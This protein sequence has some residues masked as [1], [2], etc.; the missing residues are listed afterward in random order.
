VPD[1]ASLL[2]IVVA[3]TILLPIAFLVAVAYAAG[4]RRR[5]IEIGGR[6]T[7]LLTILGG[8]S[9]GIFLLTG[10]DELLVL[11]PILGAA[12]VLVANLWRRRQRIQAGQVILGT[13][14][15]WAIL[16]TSYLV[17]LVLDPTAYDTGAVVTWFAL[18]AAGV[19]TGL[20]LIA[21]GNPPEPAPSVAAAA[22]E[23][24]SRAYGSIVTAIREPG[25]VGP[26]GTSELAAVVGFVVG[27]LLVP[28]LV[29]ADLPPVLRFAI[30]IVVGAVLATEAYIRAMPVRSRR[31]FEAFS[32][33]GEWELAEARR[34]APGS[35]PTTPAEAAEWL[36]ANPETDANRWIQVDVLQLAGRFD[37]A[38]KAAGR[39]ADTTPEDRFIRAQ[40]LDSIDWRS[41]GEGDL[42][43]LRAAAAEITPADGDPRLR[44]EVSIATAEVRRR[45]A[46]GR[47]TPG[48]ALDPLLEVR[49]KLGRRAD[50]QVGR[51]LRR[52]L[53]TG[54]LLAGFALGGLLWLLNPLGGRLG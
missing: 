52:R 17:G 46:D 9:I 18:G 14:L 16:Y 45:M 6:L 3:F 12:L 49:R 24:G 48:D 5:G 8:L 51:A 34:S 20:A 50:G 44:A 23:P 26:F 36:A 40:A 29:P 31:A 38:R 37:E 22:G 13:A 43:G 19:G 21:R 41:G 10:A 28:L 54:T 2:V 15:P 47:T 1:P 32:W 35:V 11:G 33:L 27:W 7:G 30:P 42:A 4:R 39:L 53:L 25:R